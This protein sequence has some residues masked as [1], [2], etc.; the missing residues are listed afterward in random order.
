LVRKGPL[1][2]ER[3]TV[4]VP[5][6]NIGRADYNDIVLGDES[7]SQAH[8]KLQRRDEVWVLSD[9]GSTNGT[10]VDGVRLEDEMPLSPGST[11]IIGEV[12]MLFDPTEGQVIPGQ[13]ETAVLPALGSVPPPA[14]PSAPADAGA[15][16]KASVPKVVASPQPAR[17]GRWLLVVL[18]IA[19]VA[20]VAF[21][22]LSGR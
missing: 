12:P 9:L 21:Y 14:Q 10:T 11:I 4:H 2:G 13:P 8:A 20:V 5:V 1:K 7:V 17:S 19:T 18:V 16:P 3:F 22:F 15:A 6:A